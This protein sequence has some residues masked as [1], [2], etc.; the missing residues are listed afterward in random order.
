MSYRAVLRAP[1]RIGD[2]PDDGAVNDRAQP[3]YLQELN[4]L[5]IASTSGQCHIRT[6]STGEVRGVKNVVRLCIERLE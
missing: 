5:R 3:V 1:R 4:C 6:F 2:P